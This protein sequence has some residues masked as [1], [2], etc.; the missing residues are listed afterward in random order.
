MA[1]SHILE[2]IHSVPI[3]QPS[4]IPCFLSSVQKLLLIR[5]W[6]KLDSETVISSKS[7]HS[8]VLLILKMGPKIAF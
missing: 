1:Q 5:I 6:E 3:F 4:G 8:V 7:R 2:R